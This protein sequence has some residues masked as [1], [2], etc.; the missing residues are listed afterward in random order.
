MKV[1]REALVPTDYGDYRL[2]YELTGRHVKEEDRDCYGVRI[3][4]FLTGTGSGEDRSPPADRS[5]I[6]GLT[7]DPAE[8]EDFFSLITDG[9]VM[10]VSL[11]EVADDWNCAFHPRFSSARQAVLTDRNTEEPL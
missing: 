11:F 4:Q 10:P 2:V 6:T 5:E 3:L 8:A 9:L 7:D 1:R